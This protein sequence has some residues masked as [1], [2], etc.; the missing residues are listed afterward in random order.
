MQS[1]VKPLGLAELCDKK[2]LNL[3][4]L[5]NLNNH[6]ANQRQAIEHNSYLPLVTSPPST[7]RTET[8]LPQSKSNLIHLFAGE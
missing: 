2:W 7:S 4:T 3:Y 5:T 8:P 1:L 6:K